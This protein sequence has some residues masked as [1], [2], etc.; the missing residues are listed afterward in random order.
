MNN[1]EK[2]DV[3]LDHMKEDQTKLVSFKNCRERNSNA[4]WLS[5]WRVGGNPYIKSAIIHI[6][7]LETKRRRD[8]H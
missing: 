1:S 6:P 8:T 5:V 3:M 4:E 2:L 7:T